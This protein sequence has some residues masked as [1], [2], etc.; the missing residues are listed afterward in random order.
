MPS[1]CAHAIVQ[2]QKGQ[3]LLM[4]VLDGLSMSMDAPS[5]ARSC[6]NSPIKVINVQ[7]SST[8]NVYAPI[9]I[10]GLLGY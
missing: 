6:H 10:G 2:P 8:K 3:S 1:M 4:E 7:F 5:G 9:Q